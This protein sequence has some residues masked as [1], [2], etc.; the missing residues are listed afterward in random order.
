MVFSGGKRRT[1]RSKGSRRKGKRV[2]TLVRDTRRV[3]QIPL[4]LAQGATKVVLGKGASRALGK[5]VNFPL[6]VLRVRNGS[7]KFRLK[8][9]GTRRGMRRKTARRAYKK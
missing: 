5:A 1:R 6:R 3:V 8:G 2:G 9:G 4:Q 7:R